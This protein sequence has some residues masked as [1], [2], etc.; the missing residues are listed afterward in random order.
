MFSFYSCIL[1][2]CSDI[3]LH[4]LVLSTLVNT[5]I[6][7]NLLPNYYFLFFIF[8]NRFLPCIGNGRNSYSCPE[9]ERDAFIFLHS[10]NLL[11][12]NHRQE[13]VGSNM[14]G[15]IDYPPGW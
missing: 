14:I 7:N 5:I 2:S 15:G 3:S 11:L 6:N 12:Q 10:A 8:F 4:S 13:F 1:L 9:K